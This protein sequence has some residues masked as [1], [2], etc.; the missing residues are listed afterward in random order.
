MT[1]SRRFVERYCHV[2]FSCL[3]CTLQGASCSGSRLGVAAAVV[4]V[5]WGH[6]QNKMVSGDEEASGHERPEVASGDEEVPRHD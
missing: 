2:A 5:L 6:C 1:L 3:D 4:R